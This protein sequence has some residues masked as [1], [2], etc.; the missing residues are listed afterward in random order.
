MA[1][2]RRN[3]HNNNPDGVKPSTKGDTGGSSSSN[4]SSS[5]T[6]TSKGILS[7][8]KP[9]VG[10]ICLL[11]AIT[12]GYVGYLETRVNTPYDDKKVKFYRF[13]TKSLKV[14]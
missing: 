10:C 6:K 5:K 12:V 8:W 7:Y 14:N 3:A 11:V 2:P 1:R 13:P 9:V 4:E